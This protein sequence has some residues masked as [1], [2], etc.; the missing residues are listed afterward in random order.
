VPTRDGEIRA[1][2][3]ALI[4]KSG[5]SKHVRITGWISGEQVQNELLLRGGLVL[6]SF[7]EGLPVALM[8]A[9]ARSSRS[10]P[11]TSPAFQRW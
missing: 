10:S 4:R 2:V 5:L 6:P 8:V 11:S 7:A 9:M 3:E 1:D